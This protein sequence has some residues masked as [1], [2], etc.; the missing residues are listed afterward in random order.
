M[1]PYFK[2][3]AHLNENL[4]L[5][6]GKT[7][8]SGSDLRQICRKLSRK[9]YR[10]PEVDTEDIQPTPCVSVSA[11]TLQQTAHLP[12]AM[13]SMR[14]AQSLQG[15]QHREGVLHV[16]SLSD[17]ASLPVPGSTWESVSVSVSYGA[18]CSTE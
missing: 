8:L 13:E 4:S 18:P 10:G 11:V 3:N 16:N 15:P 17:C 9:S 12:V 5:G 6:M 14:K 2:R 7:G 1:F